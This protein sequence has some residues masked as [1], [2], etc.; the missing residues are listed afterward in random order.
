MP[1][2]RTFLFLSA[3]AAVGAYLPA[4]EEEV[5]HYWPSRSFRIDNI[6][7][8]APLPGAFIDAL[9]REMDRL[10]RDVANFE[11]QALAI[12]GRQAMRREQDRRAARNAARAAR[13]QEW[14]RHTRADG[15]VVDI[16]PAETHGMVTRTSGV[17]VPEG[18]EPRGGWWDL[19]D[20]GPRYAREHQRRARARQETVNG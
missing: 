6:T 7:A 14:R 13:H 9:Q 16:E 17:I 3:A 1:S 20:Y 19:V 18:C 8:P 15:Q 10:V 12:D 5:I 2:R 4:P 11:R